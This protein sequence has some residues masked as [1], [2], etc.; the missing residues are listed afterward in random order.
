MD[1]EG[2]DRI[3][4]RKAMYGMPKNSGDPEPPQPPFKKKSPED[5]EK[6]ILNHCSERVSEF[7]TKYCNNEGR[8]EQ[9][10]IPEEKASFCHDYS[11][12]AAK[13]KG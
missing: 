6:S 9:T 11:I 8:F 4:D 5:R 2:A 7:C 12:R 10:V 13:A 3:K 1:E